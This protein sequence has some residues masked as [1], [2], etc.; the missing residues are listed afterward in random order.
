[1]NDSE[2][3]KAYK[4]IN[5]SFAGI[6]LVIML[7]SGIFSVNSNYPITCVHVQ[8]TGETCPSCGFSRAFSELVRLNFSKAK[9]INPYALGVFLFYAIQLL[10]RLSINFFFIKKIRLKAIILSDVLIS[11]LL[12]LAGFNQLLLI[13]KYF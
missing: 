8:I 2:S 5:Y 3:R 1:M 13:W 10:M 4:I 7:Y 6:L 9:E 11:V 12:F